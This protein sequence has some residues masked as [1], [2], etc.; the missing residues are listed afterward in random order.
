MSL[1]LSQNEIEQAVAAPG[2]EAVIKTLKEQQCE[3]C[4][5]YLA[6]TKHELC[7]AA[8]SY[9]WRTTLQCVNDHTET[10]VFR[11]DWLSTP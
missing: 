10:R 1:E 3:A 9:Y 5:G 8:S 7:K 2:V 11:A 4:A 6:L